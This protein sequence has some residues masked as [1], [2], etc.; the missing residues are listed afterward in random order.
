MESLKIKKDSWHYKLAKFG[1]RHGYVPYS[2]DICSY[3]KHVIWGLL[4]GFMAFLAIFTFICG[5]GNTL[6]FLAA[7]SVYGIWLEPDWPAQVILIL[8]I[9]VGLFLLVFLIYPIVDNIV[10]SDYN[11]DKFVPSAY[12]SFK[13]KFC[14][15]VE[16]E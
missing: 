15:K 1:A 5:I 13:N 7:I 2:S 3:T 16:I 12:R 9:S 14:I 10:N 11:T 8:S 6:A 4:L